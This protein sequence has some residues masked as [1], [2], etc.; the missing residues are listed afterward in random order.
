[1]KDAKRASATAEFESAAAAH[2]L[3]VDSIQLDS[4]VE[5]D[6]FADA[7]DTVQAPTTTTEAG[8]VFREDPA[9]TE[10]SAAG[11]TL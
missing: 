4:D 2:G 7:R 5:D 9:H 11:P 6:E 8:A 1:M 3:P 10:P